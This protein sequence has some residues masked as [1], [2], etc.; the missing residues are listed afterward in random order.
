VAT[1]DH[2]SPVRLRGRPGALAGHLALPDSAPAMITVNLALGDRTPTPVT[3][4]VVRIGAKGLSGLRLDLPRWTPPG[5]YEGTVKVG[6]HERRVVVDVEPRPKVRMSPRRLSLRGRPKEAVTAEVV[7]SNV[8]NVAC[9]V[10]GAYVFALFDP[11]SLERA[12]QRAFQSSARGEERFIDR[13]AAELS[14]GYAGT[15]RLKVDQ[16]A[17]PLEP[18]DSRELRATLRLPDHLRSGRTYEGTWRIGTIGYNVEIET[19]DGESQED[20]E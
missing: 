9:D 1:R 16:G 10:R 13:I 18:G 19:A 7:V 4:H 11:S 15:V 17:G 5:S 8:G 2:S 20:V 12:T 14:E 6:D 3:A